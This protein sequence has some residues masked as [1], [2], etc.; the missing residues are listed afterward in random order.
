MGERVM[1]Q[2]Q[3]DERAAGVD[4]LD[5]VNES[6][7]EWPTFDVTHVVEVGDDEPDRCTVYPDDVSDEE[8]LT[9]WITAESGSY[10]SIVSRR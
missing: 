9:A 10:E 6:L 1:G 3:P 8:R 4:D 5:V 7:V 2:D